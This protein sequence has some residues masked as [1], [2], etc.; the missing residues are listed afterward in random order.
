MVGNYKHPYKKDGVLVE[1]FEKNP[2]RYR[3]AVLWTRL[4]II[5]TP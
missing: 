4:E 5:F 3:D 2:K 1:N